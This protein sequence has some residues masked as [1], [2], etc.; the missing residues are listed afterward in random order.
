MSA[1]IALTAA[2]AGAIAR[3]GATLAWIRADTFPWPPHEGSRQI[4][5][6]GGILREALDDYAGLTS[7]PP[8]THPAT[9]FP[10][11]G[12]GQDNALETALDWVTRDIRDVTGELE[13][14][15]RAA[16][17]AFRAREEGRA[18]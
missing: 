1:I 13:A 18:A 2:E 17:E 15:A 11:L 14:L 5:A 10:D 4:C 12:R 7:V 8:R 9:L 6:Q 16:E 3:A